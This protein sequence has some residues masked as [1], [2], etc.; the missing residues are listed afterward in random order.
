[1]AEAERETDMTNE[2]RSQW[3]DREIAENLH[4][5]ELTKLEGDDNIAEWLRITERISTS[6]SES[7]RRDGRGGR[8]AGI[9]TAARELG[10]ER[11]DAHRAVKVASISDEA[12]GVA[13]TACAPA[14]R[15]APIAALKAHPES[16]PPLRG[17]G[18]GPRGSGQAPPTRAF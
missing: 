6:Q 5:A 14:Q 13:R 16:T 8:P 11:Q 18:G 4:R 15:P 1:M 3:D 9:E 7:L 17:G 10:I 2:Q 12:K